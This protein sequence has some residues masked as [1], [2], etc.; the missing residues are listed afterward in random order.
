MRDSDEPE[1][2]FTCLDAFRCAIRVACI[3]GLTVRHVY[4]FFW[5]DTFVMCSTTLDNNMS[6]TVHEVSPSKLSVRHFGLW[7]FFSQN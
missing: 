6:E 4:D 3:F 5:H 1:V 7:T 2:V